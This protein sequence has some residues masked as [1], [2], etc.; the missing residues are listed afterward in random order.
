MLSGGLSI[1]IPTKDRQVVFAKTLQAAYTATANILSEIIVIN[2]SKNSEIIIDNN[3][4]NR[5]KLINNPKNGVASARNLG[6]KN[7]NYPNLLFLDDD[8]L[9]TQENI[10]ELTKNINQHPNTAIN[11]NWKYPGSLLEKITKTQFGRYL[12]TNNFTSLKGWSNNLK[13]ND[14]EIFEVELIASYFLFISKVNFNLIGGYNETFPHA[15]AEDFDFA[16]RLKKV[17]VK[18]LCNPLSIVLHNEED[19]VELLPWLKRKERSAETR[20]IAYKL[21]YNEMDI[22]AP[23]I[24][25]YLMKFLFYFKNILFFI[26]KI[27]PNTKS[28]DFLYFK[29]I[30]FLLAIYLYKGYFK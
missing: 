22:K 29:I 9:I 4:K 28:L 16:M 27:I 5:V 14:K 2:D 20:K 26:L 8:I 12:Y 11:F 3:F 23:L 18:G 1:I 13:W 7:S 15:G 24:K 10:I 6:V 17:F 30:N 25:I 21:G 19:R